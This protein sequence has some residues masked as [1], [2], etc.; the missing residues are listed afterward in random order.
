MIANTWKPTL[1]IPLWAMMLLAVAMFAA[2]G[3]SA[4]EAPVTVNYEENDTSAV[5]TFAGSYTGLR[6]A[7]VVPVRD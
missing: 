3:V 4:Q 6:Q 2:S 7:G 5:H 1:L